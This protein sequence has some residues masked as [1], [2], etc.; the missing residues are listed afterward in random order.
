MK[1]NWKQT[2][3]NINKDKFYAYVRMSGGNEQRNRNLS[4][5]SQIQQIAY[6]VKQNPTIEIA[7]TYEE[8]H[9]AFR[10]GARQVFKQMLKDIK[11]N[12]DIKG[13]IV[14]KWDRISRN[15]DDYSMLQKVRWEDNPIRIISISEPMI[16]SYLWRY[17]I[18]DLQNRAILYSEELSFRVK[19]WIRKRLQMWGYVYTAPF[20]YKYVNK[21]LIPNN[22][23][24]KAD[25][26][27]Y[28]FEIYATGVNGI[29]TIRRQ[30]NERYKKL[31]T[32]NQVESILANPVYAWFV[33]KERNLSQEEYTFFGAEKP[34]TYKEIFPMKNV[35]PLISKELYQRC[36]NVK[37]NRAREI[38][39]PMGIARF[40][41]VFVCACWRNLRRYDKKNIRY[42]ACQKDITSIH[43]KKC[44]ERC[45][46]LSCID[47][48]LEELLREIIPSKELAETMKQYIKA[49]MKAITKTKK[50]LEDSLMSDIQSLEDKKHELSQMYISSS[51]SGDVFI[52]TT[53]Q[54][55]QEIEQ[56]KTELK[57]ISDSEWYMQASKKVIQLLSVL[58]KRGKDLDNSSWEEKSSR[59]YSMAF[60]VVSN[61]IIKG[62]NISSYLLH[63]PFE[64][65]KVLRFWLWQG[66]QGL[67][68]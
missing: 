12:K 55:E 56:K 26:V 35:E 67:N 39:K 51:L 57:H 52:S 4:I 43:Q 13:I 46:P 64:Y 25:I 36:Q 11:K 15:P 59:V 8:V 45:T 66:V 14:F 37:N 50:T 54:L 6:Y 28:I 23:E 10:W 18:R 40:P 61:C 49:D 58:Q 47:N 2:M 27:K 62:R 38:P 16:S 42:L 60:T 31:L 21:N 32:K 24:N 3:K 53:Q 19:L 22:S 41:R 29:T 33:E 63:Q 48:K 44:K 20:G 65:F 30:V 9:S 17:M 7:K 1:T 68:P 34:G 5:P